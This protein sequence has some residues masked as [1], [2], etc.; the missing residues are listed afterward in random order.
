MTTAEAI[1]ILRA[2]LA[3]CPVRETIDAR[4]AVIV[5]PD[6]HDTWCPTCEPLAVVLAEL[7]RLRALNVFRSD[8]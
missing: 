3:A 5:Y 2:R 1:A 7:E 8:V 4:G 6:L